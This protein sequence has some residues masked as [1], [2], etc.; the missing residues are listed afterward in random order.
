MLDKALKFG[1]K[2]V[3]LVGH[4]GKFAKLSAGIFNTHNHIAD[5]RAEIITA[6]AA[7]LGANIDVVNELMK[8][9]TAEHSAEILKNNNLE[10]VFEIIT[11]KAVQRCNERTFGE[12]ECGIALFSNKEIL[13]VCKVAK[14]MIEELKTLE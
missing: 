4:I 12:I 1:F 9:V 3:L 5:A 7:T 10:Q 2:K 8:S 11:N 6:Y 14:R 13:S